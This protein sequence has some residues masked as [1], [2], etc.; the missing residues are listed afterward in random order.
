MLFVLAAEGGRR[1]VQHQQVQGAVWGT[2]ITILLLLDQAM[3][4]LWGEAQEQASPVQ[5]RVWQALTVIL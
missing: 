5:N 3:Q 1:I 2:K 4:W